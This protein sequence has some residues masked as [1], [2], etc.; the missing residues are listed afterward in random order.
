MFILFY[1]QYK[2]LQALNQ[3]SKETLLIHLPNE[4]KSS[5]YTVYEGMF[6]PF[7][8]KNTY[9][10]FN[11]GRKQKDML[12]NKGLNQQGVL[13]GLPDYLIIKPLPIPKFG[14]I[15]G[16]FEKG[17][18]SPHQEWFRDYCHRNNIPWHLL[19]GYEGFDAGFKFIN[20]L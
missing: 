9:E 14:F 2:Q 6:N 7:K 19:V 18:L 15:E 8:D 11:A 4:R 20:E 16:K 17:K 5:T 13:K 3:I 10:G 12:Y 1:Q